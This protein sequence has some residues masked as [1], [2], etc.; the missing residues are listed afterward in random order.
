MVPPP[1]VS[2]RRRALQNPA[3]PP[4]RTE[5]RTAYRGALLARWRQTTPICAK[6]CCTIPRTFVQQA[7]GQM[8]RQ[9]GSGL[10]PN[11]LARPHPWP[12]QGNSCPSVRLTRRIGR[13]VDDHRPTP[14]PQRIHAT[15]GPCTDLLQDQGFST[16]I[17][18]ID[19][20]SDLRSELEGLR[21][22]NRPRHGSSELRVK[23]FR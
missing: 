7:V 20:V 21:R 12:A 4:Q 3:M 23:N 13:R 16:S 14:G 8:H 2:A 18:S 6:G 10:L 5:Q 11:L 22:E 17:G 1:H 19:A 15:P 9:F